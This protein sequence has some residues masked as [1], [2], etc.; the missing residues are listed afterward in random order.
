[1][2][3]LLALAAACALVSASPV[4]ASDAPAIPAIPQIT[5]E[6]GNEPYL[7]HTQLSV[8]AGQNWPADIGITITPDGL[9]RNIPSEN[10][11]PVFLSGDVDVISGS[12]ALFLG[13]ADQFAD[14]GFKIFVNCDIFQGYAL[15]TQPDAGY[16][17]VQEFID[18]GMG[19]QEAVVAACAQIKGKTFAYPAET[20]I[21]GFLDLVKS[22]SGLAPEEYESI[23]AEDSKTV[24]MM[25]AEQADFQVGGVPS[26]LTL[27]QNGF[28]TIVTS[29]DFAKYAMPTPKST[30]LRGIYYDGWLARD[31][32]IEENYDAIL[33][34]AGLSFRINQFIKEQPEKALEHH[35]PVVNSMAGT[36]LTLADGLMTYTHLDPFWTF[37]D[38]AILFSDPSVEPLAE[39]NATGSQIQMWIDEGIFEEGKVSLADFSIT[40]RVY[41]DLSAHKA[42]AEANIAKAEG[43]IAGGDC[44]QAGK[45]LKDARFHLSIF[46]FFDAARFAEAAVAWAEYELQ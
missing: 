21:K 33:R 13:A 10:C 25:V 2:K 8:A 46:N 35:L 4:F 17:S 44:P 3:K 27:L 29:G 26:R 14:D 6:F 12:V 1:M 24:A 37:E 20:A 36:N 18:G 41:R 30:A 9:G 23:I 31:S 22:T 38:S 43:L 32:Y 40:E 7:D 34:M 11:L 19:E 16:K 39:V 15:M 28:K 45:L 42:S 5:I